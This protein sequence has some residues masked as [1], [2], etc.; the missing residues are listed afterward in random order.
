M[1]GLGAVRRWAKPTDR[2]D[3]ASGVAVHDV[4]DFR[5][6]PYPGDVFVA[7]GGIP[8]NR[9]FD[10][11]AG[12]RIRGVAIDYSVDGRVFAFP[13]HGEHGRP[14]QD[15][16]T[17]VNVVGGQRPKQLVLGF[18][19]AGALLSMWISNTASV[20]MLMPVALAV[21]ASCSTVRYSHPRYCSGW[22]GRAASVGSVHRSD[23]PQ[24]DSCTGA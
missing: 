22:H 16:L 12:R 2:G 23:A 6:H 3:R 13:G 19:L 1:S 10:G 5:A 4:V 14:S 8:V 17:V 24:S 7:D 11:P 15:C 18:M 9:C 21:L 20:L